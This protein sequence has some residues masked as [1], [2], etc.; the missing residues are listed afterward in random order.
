[1]SLEMIFSV[2][3][4]VS[5]FSVSFCFSCVDGGG[6]LSMVKV[7]D[8]SACTESLDSYQRSYLA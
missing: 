1:M 7:S 5:W 8:F 3:F 2:A 6:V 4:V